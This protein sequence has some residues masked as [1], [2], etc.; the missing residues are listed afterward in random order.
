M[1]EIVNC[2]LVAATVALSVCLGCSSLAS[3][4][5][6]SQGPDDVR[7]VEQAEFDEMRGSNKFTISEP[8]GEVAASEACTAGTVDETCVNA[9]QQRLREAAKERGA[10]LV[11]MRAGAA[12]QSF[13]PQYSV[14]GVLY[15]VKER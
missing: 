1:K 14:N 8:L 13:P 11:L 7:L 4:P 6:P 9:A 3:P 12:L 15:Q 2:R 5:A 10:N